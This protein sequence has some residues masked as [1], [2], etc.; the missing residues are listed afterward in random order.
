MKYA[1]TDPRTFENLSANKRGPWVSAEFFFSDRGRQSQKTLEGLLHRI[2]YK[3]LYQS[4]NL[5]EFVIEVYQ[6]H[7]KIQQLW[8][9][10]YLEQ[11]LVNIAEQRTVEISMCLFIDALDEHNEDYDRG[12]SRLLEVL[13]RFAGKADGKVVKIML[14]LSSRPENLFRDSLKSFPGFQMHQQTYSDMRTYI[15]G[16]VDGYLASREDLSSDPNTMAS[17]HGTC[18]KIVGRAQGVF[19]WVI[20]VTFDLIQGLVDG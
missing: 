14:C 11:A 5:L 15:H 8:S 10:T 16:R 6:K 9:S 18:E 19:L 4:E 3:L 1:C 7:V 13:K 2:L 20:L 17:L 12:H